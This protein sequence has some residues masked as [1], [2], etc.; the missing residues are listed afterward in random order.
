MADLL[1][2]LGKTIDDP[3]VEELKRELE[4]EPSRSTVED[5]HYL[6]FEERGLSLATDETSRI[7]SIFLYAEGRDGY[8]QYRGNMPHGLAFDVDRE[9]SRRMLGQP[10]DTGGG[11]AVPLYGTAAPWDL[12]SYP[13]YSIHIEFG[14]RGQCPSLVT[15]ST[16]EATPGRL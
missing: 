8:R 7:E 15:L 1:S 11:E 14:A 16:P 5:R 2:L 12:Y 9:A 13:T 6:N 4:A 10:S 3:A